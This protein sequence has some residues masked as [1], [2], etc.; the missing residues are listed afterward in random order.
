MS[1]DNGAL[2]SD[3]SAPCKAY[4]RTWSPRDLPPA[5]DEQEIRRALFEEWDAVTGRRVFLR[6]YGAAAAARRGRGFGA[7]LLRTSRARRGRR[8]GR[9]R[10]R[11]RCRSAAWRSRSAAGC[12]AGERIDTHSGQVALRLADGGSLRLA[13]QTRVTFAGRGARRSTRAR[14]TSIPKGAAA[15]RR[16]SDAA[17]H[18]ARRGNAVRRAA[19]RRAS[20]RRRSRRPRRARARVRTASAVVAGERVTVPR[21]DLAAARAAPDV[22]RRLGLGRAARTAVRHRRAAGR[23]TFSMGRRPDRSNARFRRCRGGAHGARHGA[24]GLDRPRAVADGRGGGGTHRSRLLARRRPT[25]DPRREERQAARPH[26]SRSLAAPRLRP[27]RSPRTI[28]RLRRDGLVMRSRTSF[29]LPLML[30]WRSFRADG[31]MPRGAGPYRGRTVQGV[32]DELRAGGARVA[33]TAPICCPAR[34]WS[35]RSLRPRSRSSSRAR[36][37]GRTASRSGSRAASGWSSARISPLPPPGR[38]PPPWKVA[39]ADSAGRAVGRPGDRPGRRAERPERGR[40]GR[41]RDRD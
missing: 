22:R 32:I 24:D 18:R 28:A 16:G 39:V 33:F 29:V 7:L 12:R 40:R 30:A 8:V 31:V 2:G 14:C 41:A 35:R 25:G 11:R 38:R 9:A 17:R 20:R 13:P 21:R 34:C 37:C 4:S 27:A 23:S 3:R 1:D 10:A 26:R 19:H 5:D 6:R 36:S 15:R